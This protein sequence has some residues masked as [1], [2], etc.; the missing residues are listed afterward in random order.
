M[1]VFYA[2]SV[3]TALHSQTKTLLPKYISKSIFVPTRYR[4]NGGQR[5]VRLLALTLSCLLTIHLSQWPSMSS[6][7][8]SLCRSTSGGTSWALQRG[9]VESRSVIVWVI[10]STN[11]IAQIKD[12]QRAGINWKEKGYENPV[13]TG[14]SE[15]T[16]M[17]RPITRTSHAARMAENRAAT[18]VSIHGVI[19]NWTCSSM[20][21]TFSHWWN[22][23]L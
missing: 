10:H 12:M 23:F 17:R 4:Q 13:W 3:C 22:Y 20:V 18:V 21:G 15:V 8:T 1:S 5:C 2:A 19:S 7:F 9:A 6:H 14:Q 16:H 11:S